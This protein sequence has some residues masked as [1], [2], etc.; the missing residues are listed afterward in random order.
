MSADELFRMHD[1]GVRC[2]RLHGLYGGSGHDAS[3]T[4]NQLEA[5]AQSKPVQMYGWSISAQLPLHTWSYLK[6]A[7]LN[8][9]QFANTCIVADHNAC[10]IPSDYESTALQDFLDLLRSG[11][12]YVKISALHRRSPGDIQAM[13]PI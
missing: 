10:A 11:R 6:D 1:L 4:L 12:V 5:L 9:A 2:I 8:A 7:I 3:L 13:K